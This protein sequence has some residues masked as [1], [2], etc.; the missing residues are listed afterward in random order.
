MALSD[1]FKD[2]VTVTDKHIN[3]DLIPFMDKPPTAKFEV[4]ATYH[5][6]GGG[7]DGGVVRPGTRSKFGVGAYGA[8]ATSDPSSMDHVVELSQRAAWKEGRL[9]G[10][11]HK[12]EPLSDDAEK[13][14][15]N[16]K[17]TRGKDQHYVRDPEGLRVTQSAVMFPV[18]PEISR[19]S[20]AMKDAHGKLFDWKR[21]QPDYEE[22]Y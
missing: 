8:T 15:R 18:P 13:I 22:D 20:V 2:H 1:Q 19:D 5:G 3:P 11:V 16:D 7:I 9:F 14:V 12:V 4:G 6:S 17:L 21:S 10:E